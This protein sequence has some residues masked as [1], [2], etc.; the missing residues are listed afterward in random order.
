MGQCGGAGSGTDVRSSTADSHVLAPR[1]V[2]G[3]SA[4]C[5]LTVERVDAGDDHSAAVTAAY[6]DAGINEQFL[7]NDHFTTG[8]ST[9]GRT[10]S[11]SGGSG[12]GGVEGQSNRGSHGSDGS[13]ATS[14]VGNAGDKG[15]SRVFTWGLNKARQCAQ[16]RATE[17]IWLPQEAELLSGARAVGCGA[18]H[19]L[20]VL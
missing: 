6:G 1:V 20:V 15:R 16:G 5:A 2:G 4:L 19:T 7:R 3:N 13:G 8:D 9:G 11:L 10:A 14:W 18:G 12:A 17:V